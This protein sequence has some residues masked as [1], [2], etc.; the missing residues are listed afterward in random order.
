MAAHLWQPTPVA[1]PSRPRSETDILLYAYKFSGTE[2]TRREVERQLRSVPTTQ[3]CTQQAAAE[4]KGHTLARGST[5]CDRASRGTRDFSVRQAPPRTARTRPLTK[6]RKGNFSPAPRTERLGGPNTHHP[7]PSA[8]AARALARP[9][10]FSSADRAPMEAL[11][12]PELLRGQEAVSTSEALRGAEVVGLYFSGSWRAP[13]PRAPGAERPGPSFC[14]GAD[15]TGHSLPPPAP[16]PHLNPTQTPLPQV[17][18]LPS[19]H[20]EARQLLPPPPLRGEALRG[21]VRLILPLPGGR[22]RLRRGDALA[23]PRVR[24]PRPE[25]APR[26]TVPGKRACSLSPSQLSSF[27]CRRFHHVS[28]HGTSPGP[29][30][31]AGR[32][33]A[34]ASADERVRKSPLAGPGG[35]DA[36][37]PPPRR[38]PHHPRC[39]KAHLHPSLP[40]R[41]PLAAMTA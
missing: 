9:R 21:C 2:T 38:V 18:P 34:A 15:S 10:S 19:V 41:L 25:E 33:P 28:R 13:T 11:L 7:C 23:G 36:R 17:R 39:S 35:A 30:K 3:K 40:Q 5:S 8:P 32:A 6:K 37:P 4:H 1:S 22:R 29:C 27:H 16:K 24:A 26:R 20:A 14:T 12:G 31:P